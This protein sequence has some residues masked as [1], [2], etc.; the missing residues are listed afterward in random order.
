MESA[1]NAIK[2]KRKNESAIIEEFSTTAMV[3]ESFHF[4]FILF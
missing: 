1:V 2:E 3:N 4:S